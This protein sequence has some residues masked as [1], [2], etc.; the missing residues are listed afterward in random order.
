M[1]RWAYTCGWK[2]HSDEKKADM[3]MDG[4]EVEKHDTLYHL[5]HDCA[6]EYL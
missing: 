4:R 2:T 6:G 1:F 3:S 5:I